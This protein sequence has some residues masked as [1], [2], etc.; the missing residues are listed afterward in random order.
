M[1]EQKQRATDHDLL[2]ELRT[3]MNSIIGDLKELKDGL[4]LRVGSLET[5][6]ADHKRVDE[7]SREADKIHVDHEKRIR[8]IERWCWTAVG[9]LAV[10][11]LVLGFIK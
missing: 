2:I 8:F 6:K 11:Q 4:H 1:D 7:L 10:V 3:K 9:G 5:E